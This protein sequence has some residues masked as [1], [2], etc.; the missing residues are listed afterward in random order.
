MRRR[1][2]SVP[3]CLGAILFRLLRT[4]TRG[5]CLC[6]TINL[7]LQELHAKNFILKQH[8]EGDGD[9]IQMQYAARNCPLLGKINVPD[10][11]EDLTVRNAV[12]ST[13]VELPNDLSKSSVE[14]Q[15]CI[16]VIG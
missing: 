6:H 14:F 5:L 11:H 15:L 13:K 4:H 9:A 8:K 10:V 12:S 7:V 3:W 16:Y 1:Y 2:S